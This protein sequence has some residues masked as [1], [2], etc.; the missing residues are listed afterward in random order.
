MESAGQRHWVDPARTDI[1]D[2]L[3]E[4]RGIKPDMHSPSGDALTT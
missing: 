3:D 4:T 1:K 2:R